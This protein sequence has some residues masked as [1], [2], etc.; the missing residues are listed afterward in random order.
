MQFNRCT[1]AVALVVLL[2][3]ASGCAPHPDNIE[4]RVVAADAYQGKSCDQLYEEKARLTGEVERVAGL[5]REN[6][7]T[8]AAITAVGVIIA[9]PLLLGL[10]ATKDRQEE[11]SKLRGEYDAVDLSIRTRHCTVPAPG[12]PSVPQARTPQ[13]DALIASAQGTYEGKGSTDS[14]CQPPSL[15][16]II[17]GDT[18]EGTLSE[19]AGV[20]TSDIAGTLDYSGGVTLDFKSK[21]RDYFSGR[22]EGTVMGGVLSASLKTRTKQACSYAF[23]LPKDSIRNA[24]ASTPVVYGPGAWKARPV[25]MEETSAHNCLNSSQTGVTYSLNLAADKLTAEVGGGRVFSVLVPPD[26]AVNQSFKPP[27]GA[28]LIAAGNAR[29]RD[30]ELLAPAFGCRW[31]LVP[32]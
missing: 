21:N 6:A 18:V 30:M 17:R 11:L 3:A 27:T 24:A 5:Q 26:G 15:K 19:A 22:V 12:G 20:P 23:E 25:L 10:A 9:W 1:S 4:T 29:T 2:V 16:V 7:N 13:I 28:R 32:G 31:K 14:W 8:A